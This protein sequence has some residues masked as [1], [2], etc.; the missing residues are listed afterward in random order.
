MKQRL[1]FSD[2]TSHKFWQV[3]V[4]GSTMTVIYGRI[5]ADGQTKV[6]SYG[7]PAEALKDA[8][9]LVAEKEK[10]GYAGS[11]AAPAAPPVA[12]PRT[13]TTPATTASDD[14][15]PAGLRELFGASCFVKDED[16]DEDDILLFDWWAL[17][18]HFRDQMVA[19]LFGD[20]SVPGDFPALL[21]D[22]LT[23]VSRTC[24]PFALAGVASGGDVLGPDGGVP[25]FARLLLIDATGAIHAIDVDGTAVPAEA[26][27]KI[28]KSWD[29][30]KIKK[31]P[32]VK[33]VVAGQL[34]KVKTT[35]HARLVG[36]LGTFVP[37]SRQSAMVREIQ[38][39]ADG[40]LAVL[41]MRADRDECGA[42]VVEVATGARVAHFGSEHGGVAIAPDGSVVITTHGDYD[43]ERVHI[44]TCWEVATGKP[45]WAKKIQGGDGMVPLRFTPAGDMLL[46]SGIGH[47]IKAYDLAGELLWEDKIA[48]G[49]FDNH[50]EAIAFSPAGALTTAGADG[51]IRI[52]DVKTGKLIKKFKDEDSIASLVW[53]PDGKRL[54]SHSSHRTAIWDAGT[55]KRLA[56]L[57][58]WE[59]GRS[60]AEIVVSP[61]G[62]LVGCTTDGKIDL[63]DLDGKPVDRIDLKGK[64]GAWCLAACPGGVVV[65]TAGACALRFELTP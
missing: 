61:V 1:E 64:V 13:A 57:R 42:L 49:Q 56:V 5:G 2:G 62:L 44:G 46:A 27:E 18:K 11:G 25:Q 45:R 30:L 23:W 14:L 47:G 52:W 16:G 37:P 51:V 35:R 7:S 10:K 21:G 60:A 58:E 36:A 55:G 65:G 15:V 33:P 22:T 29:K 8:T 4:K 34:P 31:R 38:V 20:C 53:L 63:W 26:P 9:K 24:I 43:R 19:D 54:V 3:E 28:A 48:K 41:A 40:K 50:A 39:S 6:K 12:K 59:R 17:P 32:P